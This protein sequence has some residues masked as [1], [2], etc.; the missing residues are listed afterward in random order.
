MKRI[1]TEEAKEQLIELIE[2]LDDA[3]VVIT[4]QGKPVARIIRYKS[5]C[6]DLIGSI[7]DEIEIYGDIFST[8]RRWEASDWEPDGQS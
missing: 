2:H 4:K 6:A 5:K 8:G 7:K 3:G 1:P